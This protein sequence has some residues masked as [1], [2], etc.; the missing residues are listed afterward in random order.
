MDANGNL[1]EL[2]N[3]QVYPIALSNEGAPKYLKFKSGKSTMPSYHKGTF[4]LAKRVIPFLDV[5]TWGKGLVWINGHC[6][7][8]FWNIG[9]TQTMYVPAPWLKKGR[10]EIIIL[11]YVGPTK[12]SLAGLLMPK[13]DELANKAKSENIVKKAKPY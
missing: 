1:K 3:W 9:P 7:G 11:D 12:N 6:L 13:L 8:R 2:T 4:T 10:N 5:S